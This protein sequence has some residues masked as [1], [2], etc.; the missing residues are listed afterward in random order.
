MNILKSYILNH[1][2][3]IIYGKEIADKI[4]TELTPQIKRLK[5][6]EV[7]PTLA[8]I[9]IGNN[10]VSEKYVLSKKRSAEKIGICAEII[11]I[12][13]GKT[14]QDI[15]TI[16]DT[17]NKDARYHGI[18]IQLPVEK[19]T[20]IELAQL[21]VPQKDVDGF[22]ENSV[23]TPPIVKTVMVILQEI[24][25]IIQKE[26]NFNSWLSKI[27]VVVVGK[28]FT[29][30]GP[31]IEKLQKYTKVHTV[32]RATISPEDITKKADIIISCV[33]K[34]DIIKKENIKKG[35]VLIGIGIYKENR[36]MKGDYNEE[37][38]KNIASFY[39]PT[40]KGTG[41]VTVACLLENVVISVKT[42]KA[43][44]NS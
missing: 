42:T 22:L 37:E 28:G 44:I 43:L 10:P 21:I 14:K 13:N 3:M 23:F 39:T 40:P 33:G 31:I 20:N 41:P 9:V 36:I 4:Y 34:K 29:G 12:S 1:K 30:G 24:F 2:S 11:R 17:Y 27:N 35:V 5:K 18:I 6:S 26:N 38:I 25:S 8:I 7:I 15:K 16:V 19:F 32:D